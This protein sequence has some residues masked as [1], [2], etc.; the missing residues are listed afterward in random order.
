MS[1]LREKAAQ[2]IQDRGIPEIATRLEKKESTVKHWLK[3]GNI[4]IDVIEMM[5][6]EDGEEP[7]GGT[8]TIHSA[9]MPKPNEGTWT[10]EALDGIAQTLG[11]VVDKLQELHEWKN[12]MDERFNPRAVQPQPPSRTVPPAAVENGEFLEANSTRPGPMAPT[13]HIVRG[14]APP[15]M[16]PPPPQVIQPTGLNQRPQKHWLESYDY[17]SRR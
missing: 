6:N 10:P 3:T 16:A 12:G 13:P 5:Q 4:P 14:E 1:S 17:R 15:A 8:G 11:Q 7:V 9:P 2:Y